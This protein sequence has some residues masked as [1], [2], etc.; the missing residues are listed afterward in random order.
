MCVECEC[1]RGVRINDTDHFN[2]NHI[3]LFAFSLD[4]K[5]LTTAFPTISEPSCIDDDGGKVGASMRANSGA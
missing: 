3:P 1:V 5:T 4:T 2:N